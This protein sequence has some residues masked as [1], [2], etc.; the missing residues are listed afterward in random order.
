MGVLRGHF[1]PEFLNRIDDIIIFHPLTMEQLKTIVDI[2]LNLLKKR[3]LERK[4]DLILTDAAK[5]YLAA[6][7]YDQV[8]GARPLKR[9]IQ[10]DI[11]NPLALRILS[12]EF[13]EGDKV[14]VDAS[15]R[16]LSFHKENQA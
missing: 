4:I 16:T 11:L 8:F 9:L 2:Q 13:K 10:R 5:G 14:K 6:I 1:R 3:L 12:G 7:G 15:N